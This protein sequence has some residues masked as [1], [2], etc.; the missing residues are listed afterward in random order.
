[1]AYINRVIS[2]PSMTE[3]IFNQ[4]VSNANAKYMIF[5]NVLS[6]ALNIK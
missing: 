2:S 4:A 6:N 3:S 5:I 1:M